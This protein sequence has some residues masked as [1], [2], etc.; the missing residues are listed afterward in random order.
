MLRNRGAVVSTSGS[1]EAAIRE[2]RRV[3]AA[4]ERFD[5]VI[6]DIN[7]G[8]VTGY[9]IFAEAKKADEQVPVILMT[10]FGYDPHHSIVPRVRKVSSACCSSRFRPRRWSTSVARRSPSPKGATGTPPAERAV[11]ARARHAGACL[12]LKIVEYHRVVQQ[13]IRLRERE[14]RVGAR[15]GDLDEKQATGF[16]QTGP[17]SMIGRTN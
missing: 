7:L 14:H 5:L 3:A 11:S 13:R 17:C 12:A 6:S 8:D 9:E 1:G 10:G 2:I 4:G 15:T 16:E